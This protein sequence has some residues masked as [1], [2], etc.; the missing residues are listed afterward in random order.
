MRQSTVLYTVN[1]NRR[2]RR[3]RFPVGFLE[4]YESRE[5]WYVN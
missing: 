1:S 3:R 4:E 2:E 5:L